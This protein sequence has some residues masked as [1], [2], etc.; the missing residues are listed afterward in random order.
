MFFKLDL[1]QCLMNG[2]KWVAAW[3]IT[4]F[5]APGHNEYQDPFISVLS[6]PEIKY[7]CFQLMN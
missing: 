5:G 3:G 7:C 1:Q 4:T 2:G 6:L